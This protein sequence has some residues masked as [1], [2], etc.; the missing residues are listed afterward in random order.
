[1]VVQIHQGDALTV[2]RTLP[3]ESVQCV[4]TSP[5][6][7]ALRDYGVDGQIGLES[8]PAA[9]LDA[10]LAIF[11]E[12]RRVLRKDGLCFVNLGDS[13]AGSGK[14]PTG[15]NGIGDQERRQ[16][17]TGVSAKS[18]LNHGKGAQ[19]HQKTGQMLL[20]GGGGVPKTRYRLR[21]DLS[22]DQVAYVLSEMAKAR[23]ISP[24]TQEGRA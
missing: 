20:G 5:P 21:A 11:D 10:L 9:F 15:A 16:G 22:P 7:Y 13:Y 1:M 14:G 2:L 6:Y 19:A 23:V 18:T 8:T 24:D 17:F 4:V 3:S 12:V